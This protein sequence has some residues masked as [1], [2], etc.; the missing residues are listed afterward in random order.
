MIDFRIL[1]PE[2]LLVG[3][4]L[5]AAA[6]EGS[7]LEELS[8]GTAQQHH[9][10]ALKFDMGANPEVT[11]SVAPPTVSGTSKD[12]LDCI[13]AGLVFSNPPFLDWHIGSCS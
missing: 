6:A 7:V 3:L 12:R 1:A 2:I 11:G 8:S 4:T 13:P 5:S 10:W 9:L